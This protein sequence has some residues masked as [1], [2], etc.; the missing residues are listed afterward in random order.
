MV[1]YP[2]MRLPAGDNSAY[3]L[4]FSIP[5]DTPGLIF[6][7]RDSASAPQ[8]THFDRPLSTRF[9]EQDAFVIFDNVEVPK[10]NVFIDGDVDVYNNVMRISWWPNIMQQ[11][12]IRALT[13]L[14]FAFALGNRMAAALG[15]RSDATID[16][17]GEILCYIELTRSGVRLAEL[18]ARDYGDGVFF[19]D[20]TPLHPLRATLTEWIP[21]ACEILTQVRTA[22]MGLGDAD[23]RKKLN[24]LYGEAC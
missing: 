1:V 4:S 19:L 22:I 18:N 6:L 14:E 5:M 8:D 21:R 17:L 15:D 12:T 3:A 9:D 20:D 7:C 24:Q 10:R 2:G 23:L 11:T 16:M 13:K